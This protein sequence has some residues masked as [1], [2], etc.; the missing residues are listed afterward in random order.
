M[1][2]II[3]T[4]ASGKSKLAINLARKFKL[5]IFSIDSLSIYKHIDIASA[6]PSKTELSEIKHYGIDLLNPYEKCN[7]KVFFDLLKQVVNDRILI[8]GGSSFYLK[9][10]IDGLS[11]I[12]QMTPFI[13]QKLAQMLKDKVKSYE[14]LKK[15]D[16][17]FANKINPNDGYRINK[18]LE[19]F[20]LTNT[21]PSIFFTNNPREKLDFEINIFELTKPK[22]I[23]K[24]DI[25]TRTNI[26]FESGLITEVQNLKDNFSEIQPFKAIGIKEILM[27]LDNKI[28]INEAR[29]LI[30]KNTLS[31]A[32]RQ[33][34]FNKTQFRNVISG[35]FKT[36]NNALEYEYQKIF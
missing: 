32:K 11:P 27:F 29:E 19:I 9:A 17:T 36:I 12:P 2:A 8:V 7:A 10:M 35:D 26:M 25:I 5:S 13:E 30:I 16:S 23:L 6:K 3:G 15:L 31:L 1:N 20:F 14:F 34:T 24:N 18:A 22:E 21:P 28:T 33:R 4:T